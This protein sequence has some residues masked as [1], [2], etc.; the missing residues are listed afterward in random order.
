MIEAHRQLTPAE[1]QQAAM[2]T[3]VQP[4]N[5]RINQLVAQLQP[6]A[7]RRL[8]V[9][10]E[11]LKVEHKRLVEVSDGVK[12]GKV[13]AIQEAMRFVIAEIKKKQQQLDYSEQQLVAES[14]R[15]PQFAQEVTFWNEQERIITELRGTLD[16]PGF[17]QQNPVL[18]ANIQSSINAAEMWK[19][20]TKKSDLITNRDFAKAEIAALRSSEATLADK[21]KAELASQG[22]LMSF[23]QFMIDRYNAK[24]QLIS[25][26]VSQGAGGRLIGSLTDADIT[27]MEQVTK[28]RDNIQRC[29]DIGLQDPQTRAVAEQWKAYWTSGAASREL[30]QG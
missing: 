12:R 14:Q 25:S 20:S 3:A 29:L 5:R 26:K 4:L 27:K 18:A 11:S 1:M 10:P 17:R 15:N 2:N 21:L 9:N 19:R 8:N 24:L 16:S 23:L 30:A 7:A 6:T 28:H 13:A 22:E